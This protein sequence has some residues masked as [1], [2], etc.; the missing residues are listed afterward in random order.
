[1]T[2][3]S[4]NIYLNGFNLVVYTFYVLAFAYYQPKRTYLI[5]Q[6]ISLFIA[7][8]SLFTYVDTEP[9]HLKR[10]DLMSAVA[11]GTQVFSLIGGI[12][13]I[14]SLLFKPIRVTGDT[15]EKGSQFEDNG[16]PPSKYPIWNLSSSRSMDC[17][18]LHC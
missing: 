4:I 6:L 5:G 16:V 18:R 1:M 2:N 17:L 10:H 3:D 7:Y 13:E 8:Y 15:L 11:A 12:Y 14:V 9:N